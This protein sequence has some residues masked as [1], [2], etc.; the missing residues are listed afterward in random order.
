M[1]KWWQGYI[2]AVCVN[3]LTQDL[4]G[5]EQYLK[6]VDLLWMQTH[7]SMWAGLIVIVFCVPYIET[8]MKQKDLD[9]HER[10]MKLHAEADRIIKEQRRLSDEVTRLRGV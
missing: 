2:V 4:I 5:K 8:Y 10:A 9:L 7:W 6:S 1:S 3:Q